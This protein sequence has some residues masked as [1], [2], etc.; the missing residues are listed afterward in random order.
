ML[1]A[2]KSKQID[3]VLRVRVEAVGPDALAG[4]RILKVA[5]VLKLVGDRSAR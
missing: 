3:V 5:E 2:E 1:P 4:L